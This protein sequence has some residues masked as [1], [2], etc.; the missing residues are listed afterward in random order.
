M[1]LPVILSGGFGKRLWPLSREQHPKQL[2]SLYND[3]SLL[4]NTLE[5]LNEFQPILSP[6][7][8]CNINRRYII[9]LQVHELNLDY[10]CLIL[11][12]VSRGSAAAIALAALCAVK[13]FDNP[14]LL[15]MPI[16]HYIKNC[17]S[18]SEAIKK[19]KK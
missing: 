3:K 8:V 1:I 14:I 17:K 18:L 12:P 16:D 10:S 7:I 15:V 9:D 2:L 6:L 19:G 11:E 5:R 4:Q 13:H